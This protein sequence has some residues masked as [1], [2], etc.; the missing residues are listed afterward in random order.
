MQTTQPTTIT[1]VTL[2]TTPASRIGTHTLTF[3]RTGYSTAITSIDTGTI[4]PSAI[5]VV[6]SE[7]RYALGYGDTNIY[8]YS[9]GAWSV[10]GTGW[11]SSGTFTPVC[12]A[13]NKSTGDL[14]VAV[15]AVV[16]GDDYIRIY[17]VSNGSTWA[18]RTTVGDISNMDQIYSMAVNP[19]NGS[20]YACCFHLDDGLFDTDRS[21]V[22]VTT[23][24]GN[25]S[26]YAPT[27]DSN[28]DIYRYHDVA[29]DSNGVVYYVKSYNWP[30]DGGF[31][32]SSYSGTLYRNNVSIDTI[33]S[34]NSTYYDIWVDNNNSLWMLHDS[35]TQL[36]VFINDVHYHIWDSLPNGVYGLYKGCSDPD[37]NLYFTGNNSYFFYDADLYRILKS[38]LSHTLKW[39]TGS[40][41]TLSYGTS[42]TYILVD[43][44]SSISALVNP[45]TS[46]PIIPS[47][48]NQIVVS[49]SV[50]VLT[51]TGTFANATSTTIPVTGYI[52]DNGGANVT[53]AG[54]CWTTESRDPSASDPHFLSAGTYGNGATFTY[55][56]PSLS[57]YTEYRIRSYAINSAG[58]GYG[59]TIIVRTK[60]NLS[61][62]TMQP[63][64]VKTSNSF[65]ASGAITATGGQNPYT[66]GFC[67]KLA[68]DGTPTTNDS[69]VSASGDFGVGTYNMTSPTNLTRYTEYSVRAFA[70]NSGGTAYDT[71]NLRT[72][73]TNANVPI[74]GWVGYSGVTS[75]SFWVSAGVTNDG[76]DYGQINPITVGFTATYLTDTVTVSATGTYPTGTTFTLPIVGLTYHNVPYSVT[77]FVINSEGTGTS[78]SQNITTQQAPP[79]VTSGSIYTI[80]PSGFTL[81]ADVTDLGGAPSVIR[82]FVYIP[83]ASGD[84]TIE[85]AT[86]IVSGTMA[87]TGSFYSIT[88]N[89][90]HFTNYRVATFV[91]NDLY[92]VYGATHGIKTLADL[93]LVSTGTISNENISPSGF[94]GNGSVIDNGGETLYN[95]GFCYKLSSIAGDPTI[96]DNTPVSAAGQDFSSVP[97][98]TGLS[99]DTEY[100]Y[101]SFGVNSAGIKYGNT[102]LVTTA[103]GVAVITTNPIS[104]MTSNSLILNGYINNTGS[105]DTSQVGF[106]TNL[107]SEADPINVQSIITSADGVYTTDDTFSLTISGLSPYTSYKTM[108]YVVTE[109]GTSSG[110][111]VSASTLAATPTVITYDVTSITTSGFSASG[112]ITD[113]GGQNAT[114]IGICYTT[115]DRDPKITD[116]HVSSAGSFGI[117]DFNFDITGLLPNETYKVAAYAKNSAVEYGYGSTFTITTDVALQTVTTGNPYFTSAAEFTSYTTIV[118]AGGENATEI[119][120]CYYEGMGTPPTTADTVVSSA[121]DFSAG[122]Y[123]LS[124][125][126]LNERSVYSIRSYSLN[127]AGISYGNTVEVGTGGTYEFTNVT[128]IHTIVITYKQIGGT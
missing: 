117:S 52:T 100:K 46:L 126:G 61:T 50:P 38:G 116:S 97:T 22:T 107:S 96:S 34:S 87:T 77:A 53:S 128:D 80:T 54:F 41:Q 42:G 36:K 30:G 63:I 12:I 55:T 85:T 57:V 91:K 104:G 122:T 118:S 27:L 23:S 90:V 56:I 39:N 33:N 66:R 14:Y 108:A 67:Y 62:L 119:G 26:A 98:I 15:K 60:S 28:T 21:Y 79:Y 111:I 29:V 18:S 124:V 11:T 121:G 74:V 76:G 78:I 6:S 45:F 94:K 2:S 99:P 105:Y 109:A 106:Y 127:S 17:K 72:V 71:S 82:G 58:T 73:K 59:N 84:P 4:N 113:I 68:A 31:S 25:T 86:G 40:T 102:V 16:T 93:P 9:N 65:T 115:E 70:I 51:T 83:S 103:K 69:V 101:R 123:S 8:K 81:A 5:A 47:A 32:P 114:E 49:A 48:S 95:V 89:L 35:G 10:F 112:G 125:T 120:V 75:S 1:G 24:G 64:S 44:Y 88:T 110:G 7:I 13:I 20:V 19:I 43:N 3:A 37:G 92:T